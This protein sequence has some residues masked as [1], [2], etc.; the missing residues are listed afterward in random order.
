MCAASP[1]RAGGEVPSDT[2]ASV[3]S[4][5]VTAADLTE[6]IDLMPFPGKDRPAEFDSLK[7][8]A[9]ESLVAERLLAEEATV[10]GMGFD[11]VT[12]LRLDA[13]ERAFVRDEL[14]KKE[15]SAGVHASDAEIRAGLKKYL[16]RLRLVIFRCPTEES[17]RA[18]SGSLQKEG[19]D[20]LSSFESPG[21]ARPTSADT[22]TMN[23]GVTDESIE[24]PAY[25]LDAR[26]RV[27]P[28]LLSPMLG[29]AVLYLVDRGPNPAAS[30]QSVGERAIAVKNTIERRK[31]QA[32]G[33]R[34]MAS[35]LDPRKAEADRGTIEILGKALRARIASDTAAHRSGDRFIVTPGEVDNLEETLRADLSRVLVTMEGGALTL[36]RALQSFRLEPFTTPSL[37]GRIF[38]YM[39]NESVKRIARE[40]LLAR[41][42]YRMNLE[43][44]SAVR[45]DL[46][47]W[48]TNWL[49]HMAESDFTRSAGEPT[50]EEET[51][52]LIG[53]AHLLS[54]GYEVNV[55]EIFTD[56][57]TKAETY[58]GILR[59]GGDMASLRAERLRPEGMGGAGRRIGIFPRPLV[60]RARRACAPGGHRAARG[61]GESHGRVFLLPRP[62]K[63]GSPPETAPSL[64]IRS[65]GRFT[66][67]SAP[68]YAQEKPGQV[69]CRSCG[70]IRR[71]HVRRG[72]RKDV[73][74]FTHSMFT[75]RLIG[76]GGM[77]KTPPRS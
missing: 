19:A 13:L 52:E 1:G 34:Y 43:S 16:F 28:A 9:L 40:E 77:M 69:H 45:H 38:A 35:V 37:G 71:A 42:G 49:A 22:V 67:T 8:H 48:R 74:L 47:T 24:G 3:G 11:S 51:R 61:P 18:L 5:V 75:R 4:G 44:S 66:T 68:A 53:Y 59:S 31:A 56:S 21:G 25:A 29:W 32:K 46:S 50:E 36:G 54:P 62:R 23:F 20:S 39:L 33:I 73:T 60:P 58:A 41:E 72:R 17:A 2:L 15:V 57:L 70:E 14:Y 30:A 6:R 12:A 55:R 63:S 7:V 76:F 65:A 26:H 10:R 64:S 27:S